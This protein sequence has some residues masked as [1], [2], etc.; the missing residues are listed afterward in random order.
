VDTP[1]SSAHDAHDPHPEVAA[2]DPFIAAAIAGHRDLG[3]RPHGCIDGL[4]YLG[5]LVEDPETGEE[6]EVYT[7]IPCR[8]C[9]GAGRTS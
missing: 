5:E 6:V 8:R 7:A 1:K 4:V 9:S 2:G 3:E